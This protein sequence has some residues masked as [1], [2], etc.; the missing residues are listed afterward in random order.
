MGIRKL[1][2]YDPVD[3]LQLF[4]QVLLV[5]KSSSCITEKHVY[6]SGLCCIHCIIYYTCR[7]CTL[8]AAN[9]WNTGPVSPCQ[10]LLSGSCTVS[11]R[12]SDQDVFS[13]ILQDPCQLTDR[14]RL[15]NTIYTDHKYY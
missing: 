10:K 13:L 5:M 6:S 4:H 8:F 1:S 12:C 2:F 14:S 11:I 15:T 3:L 9:H 7:I